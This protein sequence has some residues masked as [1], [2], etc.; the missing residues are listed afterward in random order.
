MGL[1]ILTFLLTVI[2]PVN[3]SNYNKLTDVI[4]WIQDSKFKMCTGDEDCGEGEV[5]CK[6]IFGG[7]G[8]CVLESEALGIC[9]GF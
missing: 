3:V 8:R 4:S 2:F 7:E 1:I 6:S 9:C 5:C